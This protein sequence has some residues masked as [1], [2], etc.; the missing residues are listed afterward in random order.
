MERDFRSVCVRAYARDIDIGFWQ[1][2]LLV[3]PFQRYSKFSSHISSMD[4]E[5]RRTATTPRA[6][7]Y[8]TSARRGEGGRGGGGGLT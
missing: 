3:V 7:S 6:I 8:S 4:T 2:N 5:S 1:Q